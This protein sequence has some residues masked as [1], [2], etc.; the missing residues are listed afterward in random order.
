MGFARFEAFGVRAP[1][2]ATFAP[3]AA[4]LDIKTTSRRDLA[5]DYTLSSE[6]VRENSAWYASFVKF[7]M[8]QHGLTTLSKDCSYN[9]VLRHTVAP[10]YNSHL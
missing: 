5:P 9:T 1:R 7:K 2:L 10:I 8:R 4:E 6:G 3:R